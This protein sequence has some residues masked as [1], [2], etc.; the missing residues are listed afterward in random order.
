MNVIN[1]PKLFKQ[2]EDVLDQKGVNF[3]SLVESTNDVIEKQYNNF[4]KELL[5]EDE[6]Q[7][8]ESIQI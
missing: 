6:H 8:L 2:M 5:F 7:L 4:K 3:S 1:D